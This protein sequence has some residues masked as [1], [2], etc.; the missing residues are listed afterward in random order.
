MVKASV[1][2]C[3]GMGTI[4]AER[5]ASM[6]DVELVGVCDVNERSASVLGKLTGAGFYTDVQ[7]MFDSEKPDVV[8]IT[9]PTFLHLP[10]VKL[11]A[12]NGVHVICEKPLALSAVE[13]E[14]AIQYCEQRGVRLFVGHV[15]R[16]FPSYR[17]LTESATR[18]GGVRG[19]VYHAKRAGAHPGQVQPWFKDPNKSGGVI[20]DLMIHD[21]DYIL[22][23]FG[24]V[25]EVYAF[26]HLSEELDYAS[27]T[28]RFRNGTIAQLEAFWGYPG[29]FHT[30]FEYAG[31]DG[32]VR[33]DSSDAESLRVLR[34]QS[35]NSADGF[36]ETPQSV[37]LKDPYY[38]EIAHFLECFASGRSRSYPRWMLLRRYAGRR[39]PWNRLEP[40]CR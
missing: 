18:F 26:N 36:V 25:S 15:V 34:S 32:I 3:G 14:E 28:F 4:H 5:Y 27:A 31:A 17:Q 10:I 40:G 12:D 22:G 1:I 11:A 38:E 8:S 30:S 35:G 2:G 37:L 19:G 13:A 23:A 9:V 7:Q 39:P 29:P 6:P 33:G 20:L 16:F 21:I 24:E